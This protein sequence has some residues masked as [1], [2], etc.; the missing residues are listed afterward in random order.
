MALRRIALAG[1]AAVLAAGIVSPDLAPTA[2]IPDRDDVVA[3]AEWIADSALSGTVVLASP[4]SK[5]TFWDFRRAQVVNWWALRYDRFGEWR[6]RIDALAGPI[7]PSGPF[8]RSLLDQRFEAL[9]TDS[10]QAL[11][12][13]YGATFLVTRAPHP[14]PLRFRAGAVRVYALPAGDSL[15]PLPPSP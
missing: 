5:R 2:P 11:G 15:S 10:T 1:I 8:P 12:R 14:F 9:P 6:A 3:A 13:R 7:E 4:G